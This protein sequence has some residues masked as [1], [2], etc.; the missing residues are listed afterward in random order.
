MHQVYGKYS[1]S[2]ETV[3]FIVIFWGFFLSDTSLSALCFISIFSNSSACLLVFSDLW[4]EKVHFNR[5]QFIYFYY[6][7]GTYFLGHCPPN[8]SLDDKVDHFSPLE[9]RSFSWGF[10]CGPSLSTFL[11][12]SM[13][14]ECVCDSL[15]PVPSHLGNYLFVSTLA[16]GTVLEIQ[17][18]IVTCIFGA[19]NSSSCPLSLMSILWKDVVIILHTF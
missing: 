3:L 16:K 4:H 18:H 13:C 12:V 6:V 9:S 14:L 10:F 8:L 2:S 19:F 15:S 5:V 17:C 1:I 11:N 7:D